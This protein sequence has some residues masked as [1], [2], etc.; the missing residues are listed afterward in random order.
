MGFIG[1]SVTAPDPSRP[2][3][4]KLAKLAAALHRTPLFAAIGVSGQAIHPVQGGRANAV[5]IR[6]CGAEPRPAVQIPNRR[7]DT[8]VPLAGIR[9]PRG[10]GQD[11]LYS[12][13]AYG[14]K[15]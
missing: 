15:V 14:T 9:Y 10:T 7:Y 12:L 13:Q 3:N 6:G 4:P 8:P 1:R 11:L 2:R 5:Q